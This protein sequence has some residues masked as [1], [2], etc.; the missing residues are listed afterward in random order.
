MAGRQRSA[1]RF[2]L[3][4]VATVGAIALIGLWRP[5]WHPVQRQGSETVLVAARFAD[6]P[7]WKS[8]DP[9]TALR[10]FA[11]SCSVL[12]RKSPAAR[13]GAHGYAGKISD[14]L[15]L[16]VALPDR[17]AP[18]GTIRAWVQTVFRPF[19]VRPGRDSEAL[20]TGYYEPELAASR[21]R[22]DRFQAPIYDLPINLVSVD[23]GAFRNAWL[24]D[25]I[26][27]CVDEHRVRPC[28]SR[29]EIGTRGME[30]SKVLFYAADPIAVFFLHIQGSGRVR[31]EDDTFVRI[32]YAGQN[33]RPYKAIG[34]TLI[35]RGVLPRAGMSMQVLRDWL[36]RNP[37]QAREIMET[38][39]SY[40]FFKELPLGDP[41]LGS[42]GSEGVPLTP[43]ASVAIDPRIHSYG[44]PIY[45]VATRPDANPNKPEQG[46]NRLLIAQD[47]GGAIRGPARGDVFWGFGNDAE[48]IAG[49][50]KATGRFFVL[51]P[52]AVAARMTARTRLALS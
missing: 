37:A 2:V 27:G 5:H 16:C 23:L 8:S 33:G 14:W 7:G 6:L 45:I 1:L 34:R 46:F 36:H 35:E 3:I 10:A 44:L 50:M 39:Q 48:S 9:R 29:A 32:A 25:S 42:P 26:T 24:G 51:L 31:L 49:R 47:S 21:A 30:Q 41:A 15:A 38:D 12:R 4:A 20:F 13:L 18:P 40:V 19:E 43:G 17:N 28:A 11:R 22:H 52:T